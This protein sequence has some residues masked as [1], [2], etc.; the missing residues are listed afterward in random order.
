MLFGTWE[1]FSKK[2]F[3]QGFLQGYAE[4]HGGLE[5]LE[6]YYAECEGRKPKT[7]KVHTTHHEREVVS[8]RIDELEREVADREL[9]IRLVDLLEKEVNERKRLGKRVAELERIAKELD[10]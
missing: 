10:Q 1:T 2:R 7:P 8:K 5:A 9:T 4:R 3:E 6:A